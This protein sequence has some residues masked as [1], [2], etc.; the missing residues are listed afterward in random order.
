VLGVSIRAINSFGAGLPAAVALPVFSN[1]LPGPGPGPGPGTRQKA[2]TSGTDG[3]R[4]ARPTS[5]EGR[6]T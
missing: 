1:P 6:E 5:P 2:L 4:R 3:E